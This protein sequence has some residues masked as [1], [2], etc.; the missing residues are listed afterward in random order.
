MANRIAQSVDRFRLCFVRVGGLYVPD[1]AVAENTGIN[2]FVLDALPHDAPGVEL[3]K[4]L[5]EKAEDG[6]VFIALSAANQFP[7]VVIRPRLFQPSVCEICSCNVEETV[8]QGG[9]EDRPFAAPIFHAEIFPWAKLPV[10]YEVSCNGVSPFMHCEQQSRSELPRIIRFLVGKAVRLRQVESLVSQE[11]EDPDI[12]KSR[13]KRARI[14][15][16]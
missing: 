12:S 7:E 13:A 4:C 10:G 2:T 9:R 14:S 3:R 11:S 8:F 15:Y 5:F 6:Q 1:T 16:P